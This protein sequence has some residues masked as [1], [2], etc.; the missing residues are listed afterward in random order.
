MGGYPH[1]DDTMLIFGGPKTYEDR[2]HQ[3]L[4]HRQIYT[5]APAVQ[6]YLRWSERPITFDRNDHLI[7][8]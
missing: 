3:K 5:A 6:V 2:R 7:I 4:T 8:S 1:V